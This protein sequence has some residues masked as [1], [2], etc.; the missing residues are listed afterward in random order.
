MTPGPA[1]SLT[2]RYASLAGLLELAIA[3]PMPVLILHMTGRGLDLAL[4]GMVF[5]L[6]ALLVVLLEL[7]TGGLADAIGRRPIAL[8]SQLFTLISFALLL[9]VSGPLTAFAYA[10]FQGIGAALHSGAMDAWFVDELKRIDADVQLQPHLAIVEVL[11]AGGLLLGT[12]IGGMLPS[13]AAGLELSWPL[14]GFGIALFA[15]VVLRVV[16]W[17]ATLALMREP[18]KPQGRVAGVAEVP[19]ILK[20]T[21]RLARAI[22]SIRWLFLAAAASGMGMVS[23]ETFWQ[24]IAATVFGFEAANS[25]PFAALATI[26]GVA[27]L[28]GSLAVFRWGMAFPGGP[29]A[30]AA[31]STAVR[32]AALMLFALT[33]SVGGFGLAMA[34]A[35][36]ALATSNV[37][38]DALLHKALPTARRS[39]ML[40]V[41]SMVFYL[42]VAVASGPLGWLAT[43]LGARSSLLIAGCVTLA[44]CLAYV[45]VA[46]TDSRE[47]ASPYPRQTSAD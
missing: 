39:S 15:G 32:G 14:S 33:T 38:H 31:L 17:L 20:D 35:F 28:L 45:A 34:V 26:G 7:P 10:V 40:S 19:A 41:Q 12:L 37:P 25:G 4:V 2:I 13:L 30:L 47:V 11:Q 5:A 29:A 1:R 3:V 46:R 16:T 8:A 22:P 27:V 42:G 23:L 24:P 43:Q 9:F 36:F 18:I 6:R 44:S 21:L